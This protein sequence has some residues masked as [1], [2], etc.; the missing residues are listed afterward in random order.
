MAANRCNVM[1][2]PAP[3]EHRIPWT[4]DRVVLGNPKKIKGAFC[5]LS[6]DLNIIERV[7]ITDCPVPR[8]CIFSN[9]DT[10]RRS[11]RG[12]HMKSAS[13][14]RHAEEGDEAQHG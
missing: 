11:D 2:A 4:P 14:G 13:D 10:Q 1:I 9:S 6:W 12:D 7:S 5:A 8:V 3:V